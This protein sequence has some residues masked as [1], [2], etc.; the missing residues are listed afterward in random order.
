MADEVQSLL[1]RPASEL[2]LAEQW[3]RQQRWFDESRDSW[4]ARD[5]MTLDGRRW[6]YELQFLLKCLK[7]AR[8][9]RQC[10]NFGTVA[11]QVLSA[12]PPSS[13]TSVALEELAKEGPTQQEHDPTPP[14]VT[15]RRIPLAA[16]A[17]R[18]TKV[19]GS[20]CPDDIGQVTTRW[21]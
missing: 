18:P 10:S 4:Q 2:A 6:R 16:A 20:C 3:S 7:V 12:T 21:P 13:C 15:A 5:T 19:W 9:L 14:A 17:S 8:F 11:E 1:A